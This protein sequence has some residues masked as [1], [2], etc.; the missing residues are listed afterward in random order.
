V[1]AILNLIFFIIGLII[2]WL[3]IRSII[4]IASSLDVKLIK[5]IKKHR[6]LLVAVF[7]L[8]LLLV[9]ISLID[10]VPINAR[11]ASVLG[12]IFFILLSAIL[13]RILK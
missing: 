8:L 9:A 13:N 7:F 2:L 4:R 10:I 5:G 11:W 3:I 6:L 1:A 12:W